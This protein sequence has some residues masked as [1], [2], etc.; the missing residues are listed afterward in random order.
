MIP[1][2]IVVR[3]EGEATIAEEKKVTVGL[4]PRL[5]NE[6]R[7]AATGIEE[8]DNGE[9]IRNALRGVESGNGCF[10]FFRDEF[11]LWPRFSYQVV[12]RTDEVLADTGR[13]TRDGGDAGRV[14]GAAI[15]RP[16]GAPHPRFFTIL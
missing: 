16:T 7:V 2:F 5:E 14:R 3:P 12:G 4:A 13:V 1:E 15:R 9:W 6:E 8:F 10:D 11:H